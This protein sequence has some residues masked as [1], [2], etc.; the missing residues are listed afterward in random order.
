MWDTSFIKENAVFPPGFQSSWDPAND[1]GIYY[2]LNYPTWVMEE[3]LPPRTGSPGAE[4]IHHLDLPLILI[5]TCS[6]SWPLPIA[7]L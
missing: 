3:L 4:P 2:R 5:K 7:L 6:E 1:G